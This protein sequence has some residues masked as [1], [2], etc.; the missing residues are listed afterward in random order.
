MTTSM[1]SLVQQTIEKIKSRTAV[2]GVVGLGYVGL[3][4]LVEKSKVGFRVVGIDQNPQRAEMAARGE[5]YIS[6]VRDEEL[7]ES[8]GRGLVSTTTSLEVVAEL[9]VIVICVPTPLTKNL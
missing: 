8:V 9:D 5:S 3:P 1:R 4:F 7:R 2:V 6:D